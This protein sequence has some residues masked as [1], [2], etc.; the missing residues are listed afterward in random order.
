MAELS[1]KPKTPKSS[2]N[3]KETATRPGRHG[4]TLKADAGPGRPKGSVSV[5]HFI[6]EL[7]KANDYEQA[8]KLAQ[9]T[10]INAAKGNGV[11]LRQ[12][13]DRIDGPVKEQVDVTSGGEKLIVTV[14]LPVN[15]RNSPADTTD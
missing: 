8:K 4:G 12:I 3:R 7:L 5:T 2:E 15:E 6:K 1:E 10:I 14:H 11:A 13:L 9:A